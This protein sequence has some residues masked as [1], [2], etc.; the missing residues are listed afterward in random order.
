MVK[1]LAGVEP[2]RAGPKLGPAHSKTKPRT[3]CKINSDR[4]ADLMA[5]LVSASLLHLNLR[6]NIF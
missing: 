1:L 2:M 6:V 4:L 5:T 3:C